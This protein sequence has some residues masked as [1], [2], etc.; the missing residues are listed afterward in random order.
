MSKIKQ[1]QRC[2]THKGKLITRLFPAGNYEVYLDAKKRFG[3][4]DSLAMCKAAI[5]QDIIETAR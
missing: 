2:L 3:K 1:H 4:F 5:S